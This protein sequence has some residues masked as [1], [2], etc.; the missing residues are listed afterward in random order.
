MAASLCRPM[1]SQPV[2]SVKSVQA[3]QAAHERRRA[4]I[5]IVIDVIK[6]RVS[7]GANPR[8]AVHQKRRDRQALFFFNSL[9]THTWPQV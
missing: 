7:G 4:C 9:E 2:V 6:V 8:D 3:N 1:Q 5:E